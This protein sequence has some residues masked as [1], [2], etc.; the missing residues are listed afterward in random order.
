MGSIIY[1]DTLQ[2]NRGGDDKHAMKH[3]WW[4]AHGIEVVRTRFDGNHEVP[5]SFGDYWAETSTNVVVDSKASIA[6]VSA[7][8]GREH[9]RFRREINRA[10][11][12]GCLLVVL[13]ET[14]EAACVEDVSGWV[15]S[16]C[17]RCNVWR[18][19]NCDPTDKESAFCRKHGTKKPLQGETVAKQMRTMELTRSVRFEFVRPDESA[20]RICELLGVMYEDEGG[21]QVVR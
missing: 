7:N 6:E 10:N 14:D 21:D 11:S 1:E 15:N 20:R 16:H 3:E 17:R 9:D 12:D 8:L 4:A 18:R 5:W 13:V 2:Q 19:G